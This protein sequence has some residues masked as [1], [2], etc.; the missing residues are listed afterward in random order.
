MSVA[1][2]AATP[3]ELS[4]EDYQDNFAVIVN[5]AITEGREYQIPE[6]IREFTA[7]KPAARR[8]LR[9]RFVEFLSA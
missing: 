1:Q 4:L 8:T 5:N 9:E 2:T 6:I 3:R 7:Q